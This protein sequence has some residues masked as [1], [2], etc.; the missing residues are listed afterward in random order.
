MLD[1]TADWPTFVVNSTNNVFR[2]IHLAVTFHPK[3]VS[4]F[5]NVCKNKMHFLQDF[6]IVFMI[7]VW[8]PASMLFSS[9][10]LIIWT[11]ICSH[12]KH[13]SWFLRTLEMS[14]RT[15]SKCSA[16]VCL[17]ERMRLF[18][19][20][21]VFIHT[22]RGKNGPPSSHNWCVNLFKSGNSIDRP[23]PFFV[24]SLMNFHSFI[25]WHPNIVIIWWYSS[26][27][28][29]SQRKKNQDIKR[30]GIIECV[31][32]PKWALCCSAQCALR[33]AWLC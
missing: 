22:H 16:L 25:N 32:L 31:A 12:F 13:G 4:W 21:Q 24:F 5:L 9:L 6:V 23:F 26:K 15:P 7:S 14:T 29:L 20:C 19:C 3:M 17:D 1:L 10:F 2:G 11:E 30:W 18:Y 27:W 8:I 28:G 33:A